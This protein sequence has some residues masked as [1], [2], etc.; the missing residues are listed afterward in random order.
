[1][2]FFRLGNLRRCLERSVDCSTDSVMW[3]GCLN[4][5]PALVCQ[6]GG[7]FSVLE[8]HETD[9]SPACGNGVII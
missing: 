4:I 7:T 1:M 8:V 2:F 3:V 5:S 6:S 9:D